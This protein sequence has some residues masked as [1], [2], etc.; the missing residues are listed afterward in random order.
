[1]TQHKNWLVE[2][3][4]DAIAQVRQWPEWKRSDYVKREFPELYGSTRKSHMKDVSFEAFENAFNR[5]C[6][7]GYYEQSYFSR[8]GHSEGMTMNCRELWKAVNYDSFD[9]QSYADW[10]ADVRESL[11]L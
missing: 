2:I 11:G 6:P 10:V 4:N 7:A 8:P 9:C 5:V 3:L 1:M